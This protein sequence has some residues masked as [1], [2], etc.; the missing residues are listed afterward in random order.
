MTIV[1]ISIVI[2]CKIFYNDF[3]IEIVMESKKIIEMP[4]L[5]YSID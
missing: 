3:H 1:T 4:C 5:V 2:E